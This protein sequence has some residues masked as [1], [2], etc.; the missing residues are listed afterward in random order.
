MPCL[1]LGDIRWKSWR[2]C[3]IVDL[4]AEST[5]STY[6]NV[7]IARLKKKKEIGS[8]GKFQFGTSAMV[9]NDFDSLGSYR[10]L[11]YKGTHN[12][13]QLLF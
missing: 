9:A 4:C 3:D 11:E 8:I 12:T 1:L 7:E 6:G 13:L 2:F 10:T 5:V